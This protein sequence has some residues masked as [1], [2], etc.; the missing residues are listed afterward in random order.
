VK[1]RTPLEFS[2]SFRIIV[3][4]AAI[5]KKSKAAFLTKSK[6]HVKTVQLNTIDTILEEDNN[7][8]VIV[9][10]VSEESKDNVIGPSY[11]DAI[12]FASVYNVTMR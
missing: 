8:N 10:A 6:P 5:K 12:K 3:K 2:D 7:D 4:P 11:L 1:S 9:N